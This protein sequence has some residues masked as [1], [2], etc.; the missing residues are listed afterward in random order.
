MKTGPTP[1]AIV[2]AL[3]LT[4]A[5]SGSSLSAKD[6]PPP[7]GVVV[8]ESN[9]DTDTPISLAARD[10]GEQ[11]YRQAIDALESQQGAY[12]AK[13]P[14]QLLSLGMNLQRR[15]AHT[16]AVELF[17]RGVHL[18]RI[19]NGL[20]SAEQVPLLQREIAS[21]VA[22]GQYDAADERQH[23]LYRVQMR[24]MDSGLSRAQA[25]MQQA[26]WQY[27]AYRL[28]LGEHAFTRIMSMWDLYRLALNDIVDREG[29]TSLTLLS[30]LNGMLLA[31]YLIGTYE[32]KDSSGFSSGDNFAAQQDANRFNAYRA[33]SYKKGTAVI[34]AIY[35]VKKSNFGENS[36]ET[37]ETLAMLGDW[38]LW[39]GEREEAL[40][41]YQTSIAELVALGAAES[42]IE[43]LFGEPVALPNYEGVRP[44]PDPVEPTDGNLRLEFS[45][46][47]HGRVTDLERLDENEFDGN[48]ANRL[49]RTLR[50]TRFRPRLAMGE[51]VDME[52]VNRAYDLQ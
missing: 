6:L 10:P 29:E 48:Q 14:E 50:K 15:G 31:Q 1:P 17:K 40:A 26:Q 38:K 16:E 25:F 20:Y 49:M 13:L 24:T 44:L 3:L 35:D 7:S 30:P 4:L 27:S 34:Q 23:Y 46:S 21:H 51:P 32:H 12:S 5:A 39:H 52:K 2:C 22:L 28:A 43:R 45:V 37:A 19:N 42:E 18:S 47:A 41:D 8:G 11:V 9:P 36:R 33:Q